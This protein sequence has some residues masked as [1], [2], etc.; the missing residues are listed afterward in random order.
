MGFQV[1]FISNCLSA[2][3]Y[4]STLKIPI[5]ESLK[6]KTHWKFFLSIIILYRTRQYTIL[7]I[8]ISYMYRLLY[9]I[10]YMNYAVYQDYLKCINWHVI[11][12]KIFRNSFLGCSYLVYLEKKWYSL[13][14][15]PVHHMQ[16]SCWFKAEIHTLQFAL[17]MYAQTIQN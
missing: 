6:N 8:Y 13:T 7:H 11:A 15:P 2:W 9:L 12:V 3:S 17:S 14:L 1:T 5:N 16:K 10:I 4:N